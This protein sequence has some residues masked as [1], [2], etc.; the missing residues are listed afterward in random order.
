MT[1]FPFDFDIFLRSGS[2]THPESAALRPR[3]RVEL[4]VRAK[5]GRE[6]P[7]ADDVVGLRPKV[8][9]ER[10]VEQLAIVLPSA[11]DLRCERR[12]RPGV[13][14]VGI[15]HEAVRLA[16]VL[17]GEAVGDVARGIHRQAV[18]GRHEWLVEHGEPV[19][20]ER[21]PERERHAE[22]ALTAHEP[23]A[24]EPF[25]P[26]L[27]PRTHVLRVPGELGA[28]R[29]ERA[30]ELGVVGTV[31]DVPLARRDDLERPVA[32]LVELHRVRDR[33]R[34]AD[35]IARLPQHLDDLAL[36]LL[37]RLAGQALPVVELLLRI[38]QTL[39]GLRVDPTVP[40][41]DRARREPELAPPRHV[42]RVTERADHRDA[43]ALLGIGERVREHRHLDVEERRAHRGL[44]ASLVP[45]V[46]GMGHEG[47]AG[48]DQLGSRRSRSRRRRHRPRKRTAWYAPGMSRSSSS[49]CATAVR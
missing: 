14:D 24:V 25:D 46:V 36:R 39:R 31:A 15:A 45:V 12:R 8:H 42:G 21:V 26:R 44:E 17:V 27:E 13:H 16:A 19:A 2:R 34:L 6:Q 33:L 10:H 40:V 22:E 32:T 7:R 43:R 38:E 18:L 20:V 9:G 35:E 48:G 4:E 49:A 1:T 30:P 3:Q 37:D 11:R 5:H 29:E 28:T 47:D 23:V 41:D